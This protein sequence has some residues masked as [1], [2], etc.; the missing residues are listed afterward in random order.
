M[1]EFGNDTDGPPTCGCM[2]ILTGD[3]ERAVGIPGGLFFGQGA[4]PKQ[5]WGLEQD[6]G[7]R[8]LME[9]Q[10]EPRERTGAT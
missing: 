6:P 9:Q 3:R 8:A 5:R 1:I 7:V 10:R 4:K 2:T